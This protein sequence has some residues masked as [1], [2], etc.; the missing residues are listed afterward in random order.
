M[1]DNLDQDIEKKLVLEPSVE[2]GPTPH[3]DE[4]DSKPF[5]DFWTSG[6][7]PPIAAMPIHRDS[8]VYNMKHK[9]R[10]KAVIFNNKVII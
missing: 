3:P 10:G 9:E 2:D 7:Q 8:D 5:S 1:E 4:A 6:K